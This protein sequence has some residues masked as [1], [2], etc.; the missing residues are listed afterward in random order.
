MTDYSA[1]ISPQSE[2]T[3]LLFGWPSLVPFDSI[4]FT[5]DMPSVTCTNSQYIKYIHDSTRVQ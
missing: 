1:L 2:M 5:N 3:I 4:S